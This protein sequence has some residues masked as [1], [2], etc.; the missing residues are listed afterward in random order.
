MEGRDTIVPKRFTLADV[1]LFAFL[2]FGATVGQGIDP[3][4]KNLTK[5]FAS[6]KARPSAKA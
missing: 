1:L 3:A 6:G 4:C 5:W 2:D